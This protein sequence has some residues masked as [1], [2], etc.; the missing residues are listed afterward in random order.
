[1]EIYKVSLD[2]VIQIL[3]ELSKSTRIVSKEV[4]SQF[5]DAVPDQIRIIE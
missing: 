5:E 2:H 3:R 4:K 1:V